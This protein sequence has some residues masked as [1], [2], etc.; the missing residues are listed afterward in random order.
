M[1]RLLGRRTCLFVIIASS[2]MIV[3]TTSARG[4]SDA[5]SAGSPPCNRHIARL[6]VA[7]T[8]LGHYMT[9]LD[10]SPGFRGVGPPT[11]TKAWFIQ[12]FYCRNLSGRPDMAV[13]FDCCTADSPT[14]LAI[15]RAI[16]GRWRLE[17]SWHGVSYDLRI[18][19]RSLIESRPVYTRTSPG[20]CCPSY[21]SYWSITWTG[22]RWRVRRIGSGRNA[23]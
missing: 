21:Y 5:I 16:H 15:F 14:P 17:Y 20:L 9:T 19:G 18:R 8:P 2:V 11:D 12:G 13:Q 23:E 6:A 4:S 22:T 1:N 3:A 7:G 10:S